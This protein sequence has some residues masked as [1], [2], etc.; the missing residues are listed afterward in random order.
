MEEASYHED[1]YSRAPIGMENSFER[2]VKDESISLET[3]LKDIPGEGDLSP[4]V[5]K[6][7]TRDQWY[8]QPARSTFSEEFSKVDVSELNQ[9]TAVLRRSL[10]QASSNLESSVPSPEAATIT[11]HEIPTAAPSNDTIDPS[12]TPKASSNITWADPALYK[13]ITHDSS[14]D[15][16]TIT[17]V[18]STFSNSEVSISI[19][20]AISKLAQTARFLPH[21]ASAQNEGFQVIHAEDDYLILRK[22]HTDPQTKTTRY[23]GDINPVDGT[24]MYSRIEPASARFAS[25]TGFVNYEPIYPTETIDNRKG[26][27]QFKQQTSYP[28]SPVGVEFRGNRY[29]IVDKFRKERRRRWRRRIVWVLSVAAGTAVC[30]TYVAGVSS[31]LA[32]SDQP[33]S[34]SRR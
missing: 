22:V 29:R 23:D 16:I 12:L 33:T 31:E 14:K 3:D 28:K 6:F 25:P 17:T 19:P 2:E 15:I 8:K 10:D 13:V 26:H 5:G 20:Q 21:L 11:E 30:T 18:P 27:P 9:Q 4:T 24:S 7:A 1:G 34:Q 32:R